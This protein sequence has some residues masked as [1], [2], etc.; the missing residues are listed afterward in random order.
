MPKA[1]FYTLGCRLNQTESNLMAQSL[2]GIGYEITSFKGGADLCVINTCTVTGQSDQKSRQSIRAIQRA[3][4]GALIAVVGCMSQMLGEELFEIGGVDLI[5][6]TSEKMELASFVQKLQAGAEPIVA[7]G[8]IA[9]GAFTIDLQGQH[10][11][12]TRANLKIQ[13]GCD[14]LCSFCIIPQARGRSRSRK[15]DNLLAEAEGLLRSGVKEMVLTGVN[16]GEYHDSGLDLLSL[17]DRLAGLGVPRI[18]I[19][20]VEPTTLSEG[21]FERMKDPRHPLLPYL[22]LPLQAAQDRIL[23]LMRRRYNFAQYAKFIEKAIN[24]VP[25]LGLGTDLLTAFPGETAE[26]FEQGFARV[27]E[28][29]FQYFHVFPY[30][31]R[32]GARSAGMV[33]E[34]PADEVATRV[35]RLRDLSDQKREAFARSQVGQGLE[36]LFEGKNP[37]QHW[38][39]YAGNFLRVQVK[40]G[41]ALTNQIQLVT[42][43]KVEQNKAWGRIVEAV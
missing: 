29:P 6:G 1:S 30:A 10:L 18:R 40:T 14:F 20:S 16:L 15:L 5:L 28:L 4:P 24:L 42:V 39:G 2:K 19:S 25:N 26:E 41:E 27:R 33:G 23:T 43:E 22:H 21:V 35:E 31:R 8:P 17:T 34:V 12:Q 9:K 7:A 11:L 3:N 38:Q 37:H 13:D 36:V 32:E